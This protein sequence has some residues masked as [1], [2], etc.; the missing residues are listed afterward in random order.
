MPAYNEAELLEGSVGEVV[1]GMR[2]RGE[3]FEVIVVVFW[4]AS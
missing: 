3:P 1:D 2:R 4:F